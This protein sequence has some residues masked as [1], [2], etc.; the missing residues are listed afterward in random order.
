[1]ERSK[2]VEEY[3]MKLIM[4]DLV[5]DFPIGNSWKGVPGERVLERDSGKFGTIHDSDGKDYTCAYHPPVVYDGTTYVSTDHNTG[6]FVVLKKDVEL[7]PI[8][9]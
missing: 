3:I 2:L 5:E 7:P 8:T 1:M 9:W 6:H 4:E